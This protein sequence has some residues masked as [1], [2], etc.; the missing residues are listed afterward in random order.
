M[1]EGRMLGRKR[2]IRHRTPDV[3]GCA[4]EW[5]AVERVLSGGGQNFADNGVRRGQRR[6]FGDRPARRSRGRSSGLIAVRITSIASWLRRAAVGDLV[7]GVAI[8]LAGNAVDA[9]GSNA[10]LQL[11]HVEQN[12]FFHLVSPPSDGSFLVLTS[13][14]KLF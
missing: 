8:A 13:A 1:I 12:C 7:A 2:S 9:I 3:Q 6:D 4:G 14:A 11:F 10:L 5:D